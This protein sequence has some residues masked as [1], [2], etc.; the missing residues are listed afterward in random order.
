MLNLFLL[1]AKQIL[2]LGGFRVSAVPGKLYRELLTALESLLE[3]P[4]VLIPGLVE[5][6]KAMPGKLI[7]DDTSNPKYGLQAIS[8]KL[9]DPSNGHY[10]QGYKVLLFLWEVGPWRIPIGFALHHKESLPLTELALA[11]FSLLRN[12]HGLKP[13]VTLADAAFASREIAKR[14]NDY[15]WAFVLGWQGNRK[16]SGVNIRKAIPRGYGE[17]DGYL[18]NG[19]KV[20]AVRRKKKFLI[21]NRLL[22]SAPDIWA[23]YRRRWRVE[24]VFRILKS[25]LHLSGCQQHSERAQAC[26]LFLLLLLFACLELVSTPSVYRTCQ[27]VISQKLAVETLLKPELLAM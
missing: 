11:G 18:P 16:L 3:K 23:W 19:T 7:V 5:M 20:K 9:F 10:S 25:C 12:R 2:V 15:N 24:E 14:L 4:V 26:Y 6:A 17:A 13:E 8:Q 22:K 27:N 21:C 1:F